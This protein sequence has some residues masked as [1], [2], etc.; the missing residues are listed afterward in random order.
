MPRKD[1]WSVGAF[2]RVPFFR[3]G[4]CKPKEKK[5]SFGGT[6]VDT[7]PPRNCGRACGS[8]FGASPAFSWVSPQHSKSSI[9][10]TQHTRGQDLADSLE[11][12]PPRLRKIPTQ[13]GHIEQR[14]VLPLVAVDPL[15]TVFLFLG[16]LVENP[17]ISQKVKV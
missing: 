11:L 12:F 16:G 13:E 1:I 4:Q 2:L 5:T 17:L 10:K 3:L 9:L 15:Q 14:L 6:P 8:S 7:Y